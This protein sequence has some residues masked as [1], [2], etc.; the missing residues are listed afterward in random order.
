MANRT[1]LAISL[2]IIAVM[3]AGI[4][5][6]FTRPSTR[7]SKPTELKSVTGVVLVQSADPRKQAPVANAQIQAMVEGTEVDARSDSSG[8]FRLAFTKGIEMGKPFSMTVQHAS[9]EPAQL[10]GQ[11]G[12][13]IFMVWLPPI[14]E[15]AVST[16]PEILI[17]NLRVRYSVKMMGAIDIA[18]F[19]KPFEVVNKGNVPCKEHSLCSP[20]GKWA[21]ARLAETV[22]AGEGNEFRSVRL[23]CIAGP[24]PFTRIESQNYIARGQKLEIS[25]LNWSDTTTFLLEAEVSRRTANNIIHLAYPAVFGRTL[26][27]TLPVGSEGPSIEAEV[28]GADIVFPLGPD[29]ILD[30]GV[31]TGTANGPQGELIQ[32]NLKPGYAFKQQ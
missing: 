32:C 8:L 5:V 19:I 7:R 1:I 23:S 10:T 21:A 15:A 12:A 13:Q 17:A 9:Y 6:F 30:W 3:I 16:G 2:V 22:D 11:V 24:C 31:C 4:A 14:V 25:I 26:S 29:L 18:T 27:F 28:N 20:D